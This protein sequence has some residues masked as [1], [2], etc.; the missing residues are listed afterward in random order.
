M[1]PNSDDQIKKPKWQT[2]NKDFYSIY[3]DERDRLKKDMTPAEIKL[4]KFLKNKRLGVKF[5]RQ[6]IIDIFIPDFVALF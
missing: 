1:Q 3:K 5:R 4:W 6:H 2:A